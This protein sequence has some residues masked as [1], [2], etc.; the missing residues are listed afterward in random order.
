M[1][2]I[3]VLVVDDSAFMRKV[4]PQILQ[5]DGSIEVVGT[6]KDGTEAFKKT[7]ELNPD[8]IT[9]DV[10]MPGMDGLKTL[11]LI[12]SEKPTPVI[13]LSAYTPKGAEITLQALEYGAVDF[14][15][16]PSGEISLDIKKVQKELLEKIKA[17]KNIDVSKLSFIMPEGG[18]SVKKEKQQ[19]AVIEAMV[20]IASS[21]GGPRALTEVV[22]KITKRSL[23]A[24]YLIVQHMS[25]GFTATLA[26]RLNSQSVIKVKE[27]VDGEEIFAGT[28]Y[29]APGNFHMEILE[30]RG[31]YFI[32]LNQKPTKNGVRPS[33][34]Y[35][36]A[37]VSEKFAGKKIGVVLTG[38]GKDGAEGSEKLKKM[39]A[40]IIAQDKETSVIYGMP[41]AVA[42]KGLADK[43]LPLNAIAAEIMSE[44]EKA[45]EKAL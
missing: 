39:K 13:M 35:T 42:E 2:K 4:I 12:M 10:E 15:C 1:E 18:G 41:R 45:G 32:A 11:G 6:A 26:S 5:E 19:D 21:T 9:M 3:K 36:M 37:S 16:K 24:A 27:A 7:T 14:V 17:A 31:R 33:A 30:D 28:A 23:P 34:D 38:M 43:V 25:E 20:C 29:L 8:V 22:P 44:I 40:V